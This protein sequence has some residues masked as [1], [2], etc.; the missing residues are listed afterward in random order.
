MFG[1]EDMLDPVYH[2]LGWKGK[3]MTVM[4]SV[5]TVLLIA[6]GIGI[7]L[8]VVAMLL[9]I[10][11][12]IKRKQFGEALFSQNGTFDVS[13]RRKSRFGLYGRSVSRTE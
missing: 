3:P 13:V 9:N 1:Y 4:E 8:M 7:G 2:A 6:I 12:C 11:A 10:Y 5:N